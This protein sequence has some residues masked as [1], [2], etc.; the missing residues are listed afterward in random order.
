MNLPEKTSRITPLTEP[1]RRVPSIF[2]KFTSKRNT[3]FHAPFMQ[4]LSE[5]D[6]K[7]EEIETP[8][9]PPSSEIPRMKTPEPV[10]SLSQLQTWLERTTTT[11]TRISEQAEV[12]CA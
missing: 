4:E 10:D 3:V 2:P 12:S 1:K 8:D 7:P 5:S 6:P 11:T 9:T